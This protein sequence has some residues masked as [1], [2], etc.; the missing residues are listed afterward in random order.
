MG[1][2]FEFIDTQSHVKITNASVSAI[3][4]NFASAVENSQGFVKMIGFTEVDRVTQPSLSTT[5][6]KVVNVA[7]VKTIYV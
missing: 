5:G 2:T 1:L 7:S 4:L 6:T 3:T